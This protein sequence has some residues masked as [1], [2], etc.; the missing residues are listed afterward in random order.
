MSELLFSNGNKALVKKRALTYNKFMLRFRAAAEG[1]LFRREIR[2]SNQD[3]KCKA[4]IVQEEIKGMTGLILYIS[5][6][7]KMRKGKRMKLQHKIIRLEESL[8]TG[9]LAAACF[10]GVV[11]LLA[12]C[13]T[14]SRLLS[15]LRQEG[16]GA[17]PGTESD[18]EADGK[19]DGGNAA[20]NTSD[21]GGDAEAGAADKAAGET[22]EGA[23]EGAGKSAGAESGSADAQGTGQMAAA[24]NAEETEMIY[25][26]VCGA[27]AKPGVYGMP[28]GSRFYE[29][30]EAAGGF[31]ED[32]CQDYLNMAALLADGSRLEIPTLQVIRERET[33]EYKSGQSGESGK[34]TEHHYYT[35]PEAP[36]AEK[37]S[38]ESAGGGLVN[39]NTADMAGL[40]ALPGIG[41]GRAK[42]IIE[43]REKQGGFQK[44]EDIMQVSGIGEKMYA[45]MEEYLTVE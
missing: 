44:K 5:L 18:G 19:Q 2:M 28:E 21:S 17:F 25:V 7:A 6:T 31:S 36:A 41:E 1:L 37:E 23:D 27:V 20:E 3:M 42:A 15:E 38:A 13:G 34:E 10:L 4:G 8:R 29:A 14:D 22:G 16:T 12:G 24:G 33:A 30:V 39:I 11:C 9:L 40:C 32:A 35:V 26:H 43:Y 45:R